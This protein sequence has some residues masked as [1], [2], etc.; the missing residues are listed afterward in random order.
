VEIKSA[1]RDLESAR[2]RIDQARRAVEQAE[3]SLRIRTDRYGE[4][5]TR[6]T[7]LLQAEATLAE[8]RLAYLKAL[9][10]HN[11]AVYRLEMLTERD[12]SN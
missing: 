2:E 12:F 9:Y 1:R 11:V 3:E 5:M 7:D 8:R 4:G 6:T 10:D